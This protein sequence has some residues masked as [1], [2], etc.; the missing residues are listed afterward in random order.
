MKDVIQK[1]LEPG[2]ETQFNMALTRSKFLVKN[3][4]DG[5]ITVRLG[6]NPQHSTIGPLSYEVVFNNINNVESTVP[7][8]T[9]LVSVTAS[10]A[11]MV[12]V[13]SID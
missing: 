13:A 8:V 10:E 3:F 4:T 1:N 6:D 2:I 12:E 7:E 5:N 11:G 9:N